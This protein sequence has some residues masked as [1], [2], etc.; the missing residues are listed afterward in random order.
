MSHLDRRDWLKHST[1]ALAGM[2]FAGTLFG[3]EKPW[4][5]LWEYEAEPTLIRIG[6]NENPYGPSAA[7]KKAMMESLGISNRY[8]SELVAELREKIA[9]AYGL[10]KEHLLLGAGSSELLG[11]TA[12]L[13]AQRKGSNVVTGD[14]T[15]R[16]WFGAAEMY[17]LSLKKVPLTAGKVHDLDAMLAAM[18][19]NTSMVYVV[20][21]H[22]PTGTVVAD[23][24]LQ[25]F[26]EK[27]T[28]KAI[29]LLDEAYTEYSDVKSLAPM[30]RDNKNLV[31]A[32]TFSKIYGLA[33]AR[34]GFVLAHPDTIKKLA[35]WQP[36]ANASPSAVSLTGAI[37]AMDDTAFMKYSRDNNELVK[38][39]VTVELT[40]MGYKVI[41][42]HTSFFYYDAAPF[43]GDLAAVMQAANFSAIRIF[44]PTTTWRR[45]SLGTMDEMKK[46]LKVLKESN[47]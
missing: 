21:P 25:R 24:D 37:A 41:P 34:V 16:V 33:G 14:P 42:S 8:P 9:K 6:Q 1:M 15:F 22:N 23:A 35:A 47:A 27:V 30:V 5:E 31:V 19:G 45:T 13:A 44:E 12:A 29:L 11:N 38:Q 46:F 40:K 43:K 18:D 36:W 7:T 28:E 2:S 17:G 20:N 4:Q 39:Y 32:K 10:T 26:A 3:R